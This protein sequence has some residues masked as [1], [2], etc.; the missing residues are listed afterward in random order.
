MNGLLTLLDVLHAHISA[1]IDVVTNVQV[2]SM[3][4]IWSYV[5]QLVDHR[6]WHSA[7]MNVQGSTCRRFKGHLPGCCPI[8][9]IT[10]PNGVFL[11]ISWSA[12]R[13]TCLSAS[14]SLAK[15]CTVVL[16]DI[17]DLETKLDVGADP[18]GLLVGGGG[19]LNGA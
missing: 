11:E 4:L 5:V 1:P 15:R 16:R 7:L 19:L 6:A 18:I 8:T 17:L 14:E 10:Q 2:L 9:P 13:W 12:V 3:Q